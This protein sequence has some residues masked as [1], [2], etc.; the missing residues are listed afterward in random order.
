VLITGVI[1]LY[2]SFGK[3]VHYDTRFNDTPNRII[4]NQDS[5]TH[6]VVLSLFSPYAA[7]INITVVGIGF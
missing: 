5:K 3:D 2:S 1:S 4:M 7:K 6:V